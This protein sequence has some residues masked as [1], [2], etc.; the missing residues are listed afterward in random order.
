MLHRSNGLTAII[1]CW[2]A[3]TGLLQ[4]QDPIH[5]RLTVADGLPSNTVYNITQDH[6]G[7]LWFGSDAGASRF[8]G[9]H[10]KNFGQ[11]EGVPDEEV[12]AT[13][14]D[15]RHRLWLLLL[16]GKLAYIRGDTVYHEGNDPSLRP[17]SGRSGWARACE[18]RNGTIWFGGVWGEVLRR[19]P[20]GSFR[21]YD[22]SDQERFGGVVHPL[23]DATGSV[24]IQLNSMGYRVESN[25]LI[26]TF[27]LSAATDHA[28]YA[29]SKDGSL[30][31]VATEGLIGIGR[32]KGPLKWPAS[33]CDSWNKIRSM[34]ITQE[35]VMICGRTD[36]GGVIIDPVRGTQR[37]IF[38]KETVN[39][40]FLDDEGNCWI[41][42]NGGGLVAVALDQLRSRIVEEVNGA[43]IGTVSCLH[44]GKDGRVWVGTETG[45]LLCLD[46][47][48]MRDVDLRI[49]TMR[50]QRV[51][52]MSEVGGTLFAATDMTTFAIPLDRSGGVEPVH[53]WDRIKQRPMDFAPNK[54]L[55]SLHDGSV[56]GAFYEMMHLEGAS[57]R[58]FSPFLSDE[59]G[60]GR[61]HLLYEDPSHAL[62]VQRN[63]LLFRVANG[64][65]DTIEH[66]S[67]RS[68]CRIT[69]MG[70]LGDGTLVMGTMGK[71]LLFLRGDSVIAR[72][73]ESDGLLSDR[74]NRVRLNGD[75]ITV[76]TVSGAQLVIP[77]LPA[78]KDMIFS[79]VDPGTD[80]IPVGDAVLMNGQLYA[81]SSDGLHITDALLQRRPPRAPRIH[82]SRITS[83]DL[84]L[85]TDRYFQLD[86]GHRSL[87]F[88][89]AVIALSSGSASQLQYRI[90]GTGT[91]TSCSTTGLA[92]FM[93]ESGEYVLHLRARVAGSPW[94]PETEVRFAVI[95][96]FWERSFFRLPALL[97]LLLLIYLGLQW[98]VHRRYRKRMDQL[99]QREMV[100]DERRRIAMDLHD[101]LGA[102]L[103]GT[104]MLA[105]AALHADN[106]TKGALADT[107]ARVRNMVPKVDEIIW[108]LDPKDDLLSSLFAHLERTTNARTNA[109]G[110][111]FEC[112]QPWGYRDIAVSADFRRMV[113]MLVKEAVTNALKHARAERL[114][115]CI[116]VENERLRILVQDNG[117]GMNLSPASARRHGLANMQARA[118]QFNGTVVF[119]DT[120]PHG[121]CVVIDVPL[122]A[123]ETTA[124]PALNGRN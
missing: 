68:G 12:L 61:F 48:D 59:L 118:R 86:H 106:D 11:Q 43:S 31:G 30:W 41:S 104:A 9:H 89:L 29:R 123:G 97:A 117:L 36:R 107:I 120:K 69:G 77:A 93:Q 34:V 95:P 94:S 18:D 101:D 83:N 111:R 70:A 82:V 32:K 10:F 110:V 39:D 91:W 23:T 124:R 33:I 103:S 88:E 27:D 15:S 112:V 98:K 40:V 55:F 56:A 78:S 62:W 71:G 42:T 96:P 63:D 76:A 53:G 24:F 109:L 113:L 54:V 99:K 60:N 52:A 116:T 80:R 74:C 2:S 47:E 73:R 65:V 35:D 49:G 75:T 44:T 21:V 16:N 37:P 115:M 14:E 25:K 20:D 67:G 87:L 81:A 85:P 108:A 38:V 4:A 84:S 28:T 1:A 122:K 5:R 3:G 46:D 19:D 8:D 50:V 58:A 114:E 45:R 102:D 66:L 22:L 7:F 26:P 121:T 90:N 119:S 105:E 64:T 57:D 79:F 17:V 92:L 100:A 13:F 51:R 6:N 72:L